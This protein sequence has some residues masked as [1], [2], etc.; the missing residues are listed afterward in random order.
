MKLTKVFLLLAAINLCGVISASATDFTS[1]DQLYGWSTSGTSQFYQT[2]SDH[3]TQLNSD[4][5]FSLLA[6][7]VITPDMVLSTGQADEY[8]LKYESTGDTWAWGVCSA[9]GT[10]V[11]LNAS[12]TTGGMS[13]SSQEISNRAA[14]NAQTGYATAAHITAIEANTSKDTNATHTGD[15]T[16]SGALTI[17][18]EAVEESM[19]ADG[20]VDFSSAT[21]ASTAWRVFYGNA[22][23]AITELALGADGTYLKSN[24]AA[25]APTFATPAGSGSGDL[26]SD[27]TIPLTANWDV[28]PYSITGLTLISDQAT[29]TAP[30][31]VASTT[32]VTNLN[33]DT[34]DGESA[35]EIVTAAR[36][37]AVSANLDNTDASI[38][39][40]DAADLE[41]DGS[42]STD[43]VTM[44]S[45]DA[46]GNF[47]SLT[48]NWTTT[49]TIT[50]GSIA[51]SAS[52][53][54]Q[55]LFEDSDLLG[56]DEEAAKIIANATTLTDGA[57]VT[58]VT[59]TYMDAGTVTNAFVIDGSDNQVE[60]GIETTLQA[61][62]IIRT[63]LAADVVD[64][65]KL[66]D[67]AVDTEH[68]ADD[69]VDTAE[70][71]ADA[72][73]ST[74]IADN[75]VDTEHLADDAVDSDEIASGAVDVEHVENDLKT[76]TV[77]WVFSDVSAATTDKEVNA[78]RIPTGT[79][80][81]NAYSR[82]DATPGTNPVFTVYYHSTGAAAMA[83]LDTF[84]HDA[85]AFVDSEDITDWT[86]DPVAGSY[87]SV[88]LTTAATTATGCTF[89]VTLLSN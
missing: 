30:F 87:I 35:S 31:T 71:A 1:A 66:A 15:V 82:C 65:T 79:T 57:E 29:G 37:G 88:D 5:S 36:V 39:W 27:G 64:S 76:N 80:W 34:V 8:C 24:G 14:T 60:F 78:I 89:S 12:A 47:T 56:S 28:G 38:E 11:T 61:G 62:D 55:I 17:A 58:D 44:D 54:P 48:G 46:D 6:D 25:A 68:L 18:A 69:A 81:Q 21:V 3:L 52:S 70:L 43:V 51:T 19:M 86:S 85:A 73:E 59:V 13:I 41:S 9:G 75:A 16:G 49:G 32:V 83:S 10:S 74:K 84:T 45:V 63:E 77:E 42:L 20:S 23:G 26:L 33:A 53:S 22:T 72:V 7:N 40:E 67:N 50:G 2:Y 4:L